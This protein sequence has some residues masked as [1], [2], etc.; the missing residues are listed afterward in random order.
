MPMPYAHLALANGCLDYLQVSDR[1]DF[2]LGAISPDMRY[3]TKQPREKYH[4]PLAQLDNLVSQSDVSS[5]FELGYRVHLI[6]DELW[7][8]EEMN[9]RYRSLFFF[10]LRKRLS[11]KILESALEYFCLTQRPVSTHLKPRENGLTKKLGISS[12]DM[13]NAIISMQSYIDRRSLQIGLDIAQGIGLYSNERLDQMRA[14]SSMVEKSR[15]R[16]LLVDLL[17]NPPSSNIYCYVVNQVRS[18]LASG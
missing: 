18:R 5:S 14:L 12:E 4:F 8:T 10:A 13:N 11:P 16:R 3:F 17:V 7:Y 6:I 9:N 15:L 2:Y 1:D